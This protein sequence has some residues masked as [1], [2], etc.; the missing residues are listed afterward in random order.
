MKEKLIIKQIQGYEILPAT[1][2][3]PLKCQFP[4]KKS[5]HLILLILICI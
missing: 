5:G 2:Q 3:T 4:L 1:E